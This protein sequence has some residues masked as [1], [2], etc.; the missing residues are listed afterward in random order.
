MAGEKEEINGSRLD[1]KR[2]EGSRFEPI[3]QAT[4]CSADYSRSSCAVF[5]ANL[6]NIDHFTR[7]EIQMDWSF[8]IFPIWFGS[9]FKILLV[10]LRSFDL[11]TEGCFCEVLALPLLTCLGGVGRQDVYRPTV[12]SWLVFLWILIQLVFSLKVNQWSRIGRSDLRLCFLCSRLALI[13]DWCCFLN[14]PA[15]ITCDRWWFLVGHVYKLKI[16]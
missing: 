1:E 7:N 14:I 10:A 12:G 15:R 4:F 16:S 8:G 9:R 13:R 2:V 3:C 5:A 11:S 6:L